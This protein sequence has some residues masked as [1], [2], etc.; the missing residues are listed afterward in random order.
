MHRHRWSMWEKIV[1]N[2]TNQFGERWRTDK[3]ERYCLICNKHKR[4]SL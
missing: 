3:Q 2:G 4:R 1:V